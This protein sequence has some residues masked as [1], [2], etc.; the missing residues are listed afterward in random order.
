MAPDYLIIEGGAALSSKVKEA[1]DLV[2]HHQRNLQRAATRL[3]IETVSLDSYPRTTMWTL[4]VDLQPPK[5]D[6]NT[7]ENVTTVTTVAIDDFPHPPRHASL[8]SSG[9][10]GDSG[11]GGDGPQTDVTTDEGCAAS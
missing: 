3:K 9:D 11:D 1:G 10:S 8:D 2:G 5:S 7:L 6:D 4:P